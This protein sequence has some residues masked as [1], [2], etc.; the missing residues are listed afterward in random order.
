L[1]LSGFGC[2]DFGED[3]VFDQGMGSVFIQ[4]DFYILPAFSSGEGDVQLSVY[5]HFGLLGKAN[6]LKGL[7]LGFVDGHGH[8]ELD[9]ELV[10]QHSEGKGLVVGDCDAGD[11]D[12]VILF[13]SG[14]DT[15]FKEVSLHIED[16]QSGSIA[17]SL[18]DIQ[19]ST[20]HDCAIGF[21]AEEVEGE[22]G[23]V[24]VIEVFGHDDGIIIIG[25][26]VDA[27]INGLFAWDHF[28]DFGIQFIDCGIEGCENGRGAEQVKAIFT[29]ERTENLLCQGLS[30]ENVVWGLPM[31]FQVVFAV[32]TAQTEISEG[33]GKLLGIGIGAHVLQ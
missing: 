1:G 26:R 23:A 20:D 18:N 13:V 19:I 28:Q 4:L 7:T 16:L 3:D 8:G 9:W 5:E 15:T 6:A 10:A 32:T 21:Q 33:V 2:K 31:V 27:V 17:K 12:N 25:H 22:T 11:V 29:E 24:Q 14:Q 30:G